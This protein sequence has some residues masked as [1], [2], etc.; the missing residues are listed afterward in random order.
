LEVVAAAAGGGCVEVEDRCCLL[1]LLLRE[2]H[3]PPNRGVDFYFFEFLPA[4][5]RS[6][7]LF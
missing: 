3:F 1:L 4:K 6:R 2:L 7:F 5:S